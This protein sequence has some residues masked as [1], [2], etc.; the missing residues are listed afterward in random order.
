[1]HVVEAATRRHIRQ[2]TYL[3]LPEVWL[4]RG[5][6][7]RQRFV[8]FDPANPQRTSGGPPG[9]DSRPCSACGHPNRAEDRFCG[10][11]GQPLSAPPLGA[12]PAA[13]LPA[14]R[15]E[16]RRI[17]VLCLELA[18]ADRARSLDLEEYAMLV[19][20]LLGSYTAE[21]VR[22]GGHVA[23]HLGDAVLAYFGYPQA[24]EDAA[25]R[26]VR[27]G[28]TVAAASAARRGHTGSVVRIGVHTGFAVVALGSGAESLVLGDTVHV[29]TRLQRR[30][31]PNTVVVSESTA[32]LVPG[33]L[34]TRE[35]PADG[36]TG[37]A[38]L[39]VLGIVE[40]ASDAAAA[41]R[42]LTPFVGRRHELAVL[43]DRW[44][45]VRE[46]AG[47]AV[48]IIG[49]AGIG[50]SRLV[51]RFRATLQGERHTWTDA[52]CSP[53]AR[54]SALHPIVELQRRGLPAGP[55]DDAALRA[56][57]T[58]H[59]AAVGLDPVETV[60]LL[61][62][63]H[64]VAEVP[65]PAEGHLAA[66]GIRR[67]TF[68]LL[69]EWL[70]R[71]GAGDPA[72]VLL[73]DVHWADPSTIELLGHVLE[74][75][76][77][78]RVLL[79]MTARDAFEVPW[80][81]RGHL[82]HLGLQRLRRPEQATMVREVAGGGRIPEGWTDEITRRADGVPLFIEELTRSALEAVPGAGAPAPAFP[83]DVPGTLVDSLTVRID[84]LGGAK[85][86]VQL[87]AVVGREFDEAVLAAVAGQDATAVAD[88]L[89]AAVQAELLLRRG[90]GG[91]ARYVFRHALV[92]DA[93]Y[94]LLLRHTRRAHHARVAS[95]LVTRFPEMAAAQP[96]LVAQH[97]TDAGD[98]AGA[99]V[100]WTRAAERANGQAAHAEA[101]SHV[102]A[103]LAAAQDLSAGATRDRTE[104]ELRLV[105]GRALIATRGFAD[106][107]TRTAWDTAGD[108][109][110]RVADPTLQGVVY[111][112]R[113]S[114]LASGGDIAESLRSY[115]AALELGERTGDRTLTMAG[116]R[117]CA[118]ASF[119]TGR[120]QQALVHLQCAE[121]LYDPSEST[122]LA[123][124]FT[125][126]PGHLAMC[127][128][129]CMLWYAG[130][131]DR[132]RELLRRALETSR[133]GGRA[134]QVGLALALG[135]MNA[136]PLRRDPDEGAALAEEALALGSACGLSLIEAVGHLGV[137][138]ANA[139]GSPG[140]ETIAACLEASARMSSTGNLA[141][142]PLVLASLA[143]LQQMAGL[144]GDARATLDAAR[145]L[146]GSTGQTFHD[147]EIERLSGEAAL[148]ADI[149]DVAA[150]EQAFARAITLA[151]QQE[152]RILELR[153]AT[154]LARLRVAAG[155]PAAARDALAP[156]HGWFTEGFDTR[157]LAEARA[158]WTALPSPG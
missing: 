56:R 122:S 137:A 51:Q 27:A 55:L 156:I 95:V 147:A 11:C 58:A 34:R 150:A 9:A 117:G 143:E 73:E 53:Y 7:R 44:E 148:A 107:A 49:E 10:V 67:R 38:A 133:S 13:S 8:H 141:A 16:R 52:R 75:M 129:T 3:A 89:D 74:Q 14:G 79:L 153:A 131:V 144:L 93:A 63:L 82:T 48:L 5:T 6:A 103:G 124:R 94:D 86:L 80:P 100:W 37:E 132:S 25:E 81:A 155:R 59:A 33:L 68:T 31:A 36:S 60:P 112:S 4:C 20:D 78:G 12:P 123:A 29:A 39:E 102:A 109:A 35:L 151:R 118:E 26:A 126:D 128:G 76:A 28:L 145:G 21:L 139:F 99:A 30:A 54:D 157:D 70:L 40:S 88:A 138:W 134:Y 45:H 121:A 42:G 19:H 120:L 125:D 91:E 105:Q 142:A 146:A 98:A 96:E 64:G 32:R 46:G 66:E 127:F 140:P 154:S 158:V 130:H 50:K 47:Q 65:S 62:T 18:Q 24:T 149:P 85:E 83:S 72:V 135:V 113:G 92:R 114:A 97:L 136:L 15:G 119:Y 115:R 2:D 108:L 90:T 41:G 116:H 110:Q 106:F 1:M 22:Y 101:L 84:R 152:A 43:A 71:L 17:T 104:L 61:A 69:T 87:A 23:S 77:R 57:L 111:Y